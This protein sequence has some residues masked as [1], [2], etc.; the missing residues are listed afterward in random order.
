MK[1]VK[2]GRLAFL[3]AAILALVAVAAPGT[4]AAKDRNQDRIP[5]RWEKR[6]KLSLKVDQRKKDQDR[7]GLRNRG[8]WLSDTNPRDRDSDDD[9][10]SDGKEKAGII[11]AYDAETGTLTLTVY[12]GG[13]I[14]GEVDDSTRVK[15][16][17]DSA[18]DGSDSSGS[19]DSSGGE[20]SR[21]GSNRGPGGATSLHRGGDGSSDDDSDDSQED[22]SDD[23]S[24]DS[25]SDDSSDDSEDH[26]DDD[27]H[28][29]DCSVADL[30]EGVEVTEARLKFTASGL[31]FTRIEI[32]PPATTT[33]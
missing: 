29:Y 11:S 19:D 3:L 22:S 16:E 24:D 6:H 15:C 2:N 7:D 23:S 12:A 13:S 28:G 8:E 1:A 5:D 17:D 30:A 32:V 21:S 4:A 9:G 10:I 14:T 26:A 18:D 33:G 20:G 25:D 31:T 27:S